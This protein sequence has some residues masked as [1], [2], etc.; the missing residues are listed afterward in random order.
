MSKWISADLSGDVKLDETAEKQELDAARE[1][2][3]SD[4]VDPDSGFLASLSAA[5]ENAQVPVASL[6][7]SCESTC[8]GC[9]EMKGLSA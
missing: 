5:A 2:V 9:C 3:L 8:P 6:T 1:A 4:I 7:S